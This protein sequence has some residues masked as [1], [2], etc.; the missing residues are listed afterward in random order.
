MTD[1]FP[2]KIEI[3]QG[4]GGVITGKFSQ[5]AQDSLQDTS[6]FSVLIKELR[7]KNRFILSNDHSIFLDKYIEYARH[8][9]TLKFTKGN[10]FYRARINALEKKYECF[11][12]K[13][14]G[15]PPA[16]EAS[17]GRVNP[18]GIP[19]LY[20][21]SNID[22]AVSE[23]RPWIGCKITVAEFALKKGISVVNFSNKVSR[24]ALK[25]EQCEVKEGIWRDWISYLFSMPFDPRDD[26]AYIP[27]QYISERF[28]KEGFDG[29]IYDSAL[30]EDEDSYNLC[31]FDV[32]AAKPLKRS[33]VT[34][35][36]MGIIKMNAEDI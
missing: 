14:M 33:K 12:L 22:T 10:K 2:K 16:H 11:P 32:S 13:Q 6:T 23:V 7:F 20:L 1:N 19:Y 5:E 4:N 35:N 17:H 8:S 30:Y 21:A 9:K 27:T 24:N 26:I 29:I 34:V 25:D 28:K 15:A 36:S 31:L 3:R 18:V